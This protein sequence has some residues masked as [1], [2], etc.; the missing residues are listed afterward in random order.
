VITLAND[1]FLRAARGERVERT[2]VWVMR[3]AGR[4]LPEYRAVR[5][6]HSFLDVAHTPELC[7][8]VTVQP[9]DRLGVDA[10]ILF[11]DILLPLAAMGIGVDFV[12]QPVLE[13]T[14]DPA[15]GVASLR[16]PDPEADWKFLGDCVHATVAKLDG[17][18]PLIGFAG[19]PFTVATY[20]LEGSSKHHSATRRFLHSDPEGFRELLFFLADRLAEWLRV[21]IEAGVAAVQLFD[22]WAG[23]LSPADQ[24][25]FSLPAAQRVL[26]KVAAPSDLPTIYFAPGAGGALTAQAELGTTVLGVDWRVDLAEVRAAHPEKPLQ[27]NL[28][29][30][31]LLGSP[32][33]IE[34]G[35]RRSR[36]RSS[37]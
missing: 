27:G 1:S 17:R 32:A 31:V 21:Q 19:A 18:V 5:E 33:G 34:S 15:A 36:T 3:Q 10:A 8:E 23:V 4:V 6:K 37:W 22:S 11:S 26:E 29:P 35:V 30:G 16:R 2:P 24:V 13:R 14:H 25:R 28:D 12:P 20:I 9:V 7:A